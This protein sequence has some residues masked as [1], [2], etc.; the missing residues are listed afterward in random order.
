[1]VG[2]RPQFLL[3]EARV[4]EVTLAAQMMLA[5]ALAIPSLERRCYTVFEL[6]LLALCGVPTL[7]EWRQRWI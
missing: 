4:S 2:E 7:A 1:M 3:L 5:A 6:P